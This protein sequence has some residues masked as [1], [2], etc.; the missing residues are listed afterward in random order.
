MRSSLYM[1]LEDLRQLSYEEK[2]DIDQETLSGLYASYGRKKVFYIMCDREARI[3]NQIK[4]RRRQRVMQD[5]K[6]KAITK[7]HRNSARKIADRILSIYN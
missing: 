5:K 3:G 7:D 1:T 2:Q 6:R 4:E